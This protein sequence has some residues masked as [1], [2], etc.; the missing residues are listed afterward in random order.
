M[1]TKKR[2]A[3]TAATAAAGRLHIRIKLQQAS[4][5]VAVTMELQ[6]SSLVLPIFAIIRL[7][8]MQQ[9]VKKEKDKTSFKRGIP[10]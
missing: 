5:L 1:L 3:F 2:I 4:S 6:P 10:A 8:K 9:K 7:H